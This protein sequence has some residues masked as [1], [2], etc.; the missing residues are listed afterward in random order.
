MLFLLELKMFEQESYPLKRDRDGYYYFS[1]PFDTTKWGF[2]DAIE[3]SKFSERLGRGSAFAEISHPVTD[4]HQD[5]RVI[6]ARLSTIDV[7]RI[8]GKIDLVQNNSEGFKCRITP[9]GHFAGSL[10]PSCSYR[11]APRVIVDD[12]GKVIDIVTFDFVL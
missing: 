1:V 4:D 7:N 9:H 2:E 6:S 3:T 5:P 8:M 11:V 10:I 12:E